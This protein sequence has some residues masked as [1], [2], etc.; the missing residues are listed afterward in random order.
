MNRR[1]KVL[2]IALAAV[3]AF[4]GVSA[5]AAQAELEFHSEVKKGFTVGEQKTENV[6]TTTAGNAKCKNATFSS[7]EE[8]AEKTN[9]AADFSRKE[10]RLIPSY[11]ECSAFGQKAEVTGASCYYGISPHPISTWMGDLVGT[12]GTCAIHIKVPGGNCSLTIEE[13]VPEDGKVELAN[14]GAGSSRSI[15]LTWKLT[16]ISYGV[17]GPGTICGSEGKHVDGKYTGS[18]L[19]KGYKD[20]AHTEQVGIWQE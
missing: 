3:F 12:T 18:T 14:E 20:K 13:Q 6:Y 7:E 5:A 8:V 19:L 9:G 4:G 15:L 11:G 1:L 10:A 17:T 16:G 2:G